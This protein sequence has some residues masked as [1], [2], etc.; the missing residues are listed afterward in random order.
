MNPPADPQEPIGDLGD[1]E[2]AV[3]TLVWK[4][5]WLTV[6]E[7]YEALRR[8]R[9]IA[10]TTVMTTMARL[11][12]KGFLDRKPE[13]RSYLY[14]ARHSRLEVA[15][16]F[17]GKILERFFDGRRSEAV[18]T[19]LGEGDNLD[20]KEVAKIMESLEKREGKKSP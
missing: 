12:E 5:E 20:E 4:G 17:L 19:L 6:R 18:A 15:K 7:V 9:T 8:D 14:N 16:S 11:F 1:L 3:M 13:G 10:Y 2:S